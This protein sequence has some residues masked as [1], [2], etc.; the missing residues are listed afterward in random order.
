MQNLYGRRNLLHQV[1]YQHPLANPTLN[2][3]CI[4]CSVTVSQVAAAVNVRIIYVFYV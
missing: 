2:S 3:D 1:Q 4:C